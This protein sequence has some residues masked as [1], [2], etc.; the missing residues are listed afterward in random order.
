[1]K[2]NVWCPGKRHVRTAFGTVHARS[3][4]QTASGSGGALKRLSLATLDAWMVM[5][6]RGR[7]IR[8]FVLKC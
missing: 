1:M 3:F 6:I 4:Y 8:H 2:G 5:L 7:L